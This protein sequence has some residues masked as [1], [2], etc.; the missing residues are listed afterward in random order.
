MRKTL[1]SFFIALGTLT[2]VSAQQVLFDQT[3][4]AT[5]TGIPCQ[6]FETTYDAYDTEIADEF[7]IPAGTTWSIDSF[8]VGGFHGGNGSTPILPTSGILFRIHNDNAGSPGTVVFSDSVTINA[9]PNENGTL[10]AIFDEPIVLTAGTY[11]FSSSANKTFATTGQWYARLDSSGTGYPAKWRNP[12]AGFAVGCTSWSNI[13]TCF[14]TVNSTYTG[15]VFRV[16]GCEGIKP[17]IAF[18]SDT[19]LCENESFTLSTGSANTSFQHLWSNNAITNAISVSQAGIYSVTVLDTS[20][21]CSS[22]KAMEVDIA[23]PIL[24]VLNDDTTCLGVPKVFS[25]APCNTCSVLWSSGSTNNLTAFSTDGYL[26]VVSTDTVSGCTESDS[27]YLTVIDPGLVLLPGNVADLCDGSEITLSTTLNYENYLWWDKQNPAL[28]TDSITID[29]DGLYFI[30]VTDANGCEAEDSVLVVLRPN[31]TPVINS[32]FDNNWN[33]RLTTQD[34]YDSYAWSNG[35]SD[36][37]NTVTTNG[38]YRV[39]VTNEFGCEGTAFV[40]VYTIGVD[41]EIANQL[42]L[43]PNPATDYFQI[44]WPAN[45]LQN[46]QSTLYNVE[47]KVVMQF[48]VTQQNQR[49]DVANLP[50]GTYILATDSPDGLAKTTIIIQ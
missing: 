7:V 35:S 31:P 11:W 20:S 32:Q 36:A 38:L 22:V 46:A 23:N 27:A 42:K 33:I 6:N 12:N 9:D 40:S 29:Q 43:Y 18:S 10:V 14:T 39:T 25:V 21:G 50:K 19:T 5:T 3:T 41:E 45:W 8:M 17:H 15:S 4:A 16:Y 49:I 2:T 26:S 34:A 37:I 28:Q 30:T 1:L 13:G 44:E 48:S 47:G 24:S